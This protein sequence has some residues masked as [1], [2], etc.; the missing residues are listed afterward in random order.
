MDYRRRVILDMTPEGKFRRLPGIPLGTRIA[1]A[2]VVVALIAGGLA[3]GAFVVGVALTLI[4]VALVAV[5][6]AYVA[7]KVE[8]WRA[9]RSIGGQRNLF[10]P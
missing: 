7:F 9:R 5:L 2:A 1:V 4:P 8:L 6:V 10:R 3:I